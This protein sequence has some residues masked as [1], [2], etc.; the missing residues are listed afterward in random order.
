MVLDGRSGCEELEGGRW[1]VVEK[2]DWLHGIHFGCLYR[3]EE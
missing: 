3:M 1:G 2:E